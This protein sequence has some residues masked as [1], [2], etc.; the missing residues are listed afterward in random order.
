MRRIGLVPLFAGAALAIGPIVLASSA[1][2]PAP[3]Q[4]LNHPQGTNAGIFAFTGNCATCHD[5]GRN[6]APDRYALNSRTPEEVLAKISTGPHAEY[7]R[8]LSEFQK[9]VVAVYV[10][11]RPLGASAAGD[12]TTMKNRC[13]VAKPFRPFTGSEWNGWGVDPTNSRFQTNPGLTAEDTPKLAL[14]WAFGF[15]YGNSSYG[16]P[17]VVGGRVFVGSDTGFVYSLDAESGC[18]HWSF[19]AAAGVRTAPTV[20]PGR[21]AG[22]YLLYFGDIRANVYAVNAETGAVVWRERLDAHPIARVTGAPK[23]VEGRLYVPL[24]SLEESGAGNPLYPCCTFRGGIAA[25]DALTG[26]RLWK[27][28]TVAQEPR[29]TRVTSRGTQLWAP[30]GA[31]VWSSPTVD[32]QR[33]AVYIATGNGYTEPA[34]EASDAVLAFDIETGKRL[35]VSQVMAN[36]AYVRDCPGIYRPNVPKDNK[37]ETC[38]DELGPDMD[39]G[40]AP[41]L[42][43][44]ANGK[45]YI[46]IGQKD[47]HAWGLDPDNK[48]AVV[49]SRQLGL[50]W[51]NGGGGMMWGSAADTRFAYFPVTR[52]DDR[53]GL[54]AVNIAN[55]EIAWRARPPVG[56]SA[57]VTVMPGVVFAGSSTGTV[58]AFSTIDGRSL[59]SFDTNRPFDTVNGVPAKG[60]NINAA[61][62]VVAG[63][64]VF[65]PSGY[66]DL[67]GGNR[68]NVLLAFGAAAT[69]SK[70]QQ[71]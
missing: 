22:S 61:G 16:Q 53:L 1:Q 32:L 43:R 38:P 33:R 30:A 58:Y 60:G 34:D 69:T 67:G 10:G 68:G 37:S 36:D 48:G 4:D 28:F 25:Y 12:A 9:R 39:F 17:S 40:N 41:I 6:G 50:G 66:S 45:S 35:W 8:T 54:A 63:G 51:E 23:L 65:V 15:P 47:G 29:K 5:T 57:P 11:G 55:G 18:V 3:V 13:E 27:S 70:E 31:G 2:A 52:T 42:R 26:N 59:W 71:H 7:A 49:W 21:T 20:G 64:M 24:S 56:A 44:L 14:K 19:R 46:V 62:P